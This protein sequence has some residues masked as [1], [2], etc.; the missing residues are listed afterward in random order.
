MSSSGGGVSSSNNN[1]INDATSSLGLKMSGLNLMSN[2]SNSS[3]GPPGLSGSTVSTSSIDDRA[4]PHDSSIDHS[5]SAAGSF[6]GSTPSSPINH[7]EIIGGG[8][9]SRPPGLLGGVGHGS[10]S[11]ASPILGSGGNT[12]PGLHSKNSSTT[13][14][15]LTL[16]PNSSVDG[17]SDLYSRQASPFQVGSDSG[18]PAMPFLRNDG[19]RGDV[20]GDYGGGITSTFGG[21]GSFDLVDND[22]NYNSSASNDNDGLLGLDALRDRAYSSPGPMARSFESAP[23]LRGG[24]PPSG[25]GGGSG[26]GGGGSVV[27]ADAGAPGQRRRGVS[28]NNSGRS[29]G[30]ARP[31]LSGSVH[32]SSTNS[33]PS[34]ELHLGGLS[35][36]AGDMSLGG[37]VVPF[38]SGGRSSDPSPTRQTQAETSSIASL[39]SASE[40][41]SF[42]AIGRPE[43]S[44]NARE[45]EPSNRRRSIAG[46]ETSNLN[47]RA[48]YSQYGN[49]EQGY[50][51]SR[52]RSIGTES[53][54]EFYQQQQQQH[55]PQQH[56]GGGG[57]GYAEHGQDHAMSQKLG[58]LPSMSSQIH[59]KQRMPPHHSG[60]MQPPFNPMMLPQPKHQRSYSQPGPRMAT[61]PDQ[62][63]Q[64]GGSVGR[65][66]PS[67]YQNNGMDNNNSGHYSR[68][69]PPRYIGAP[70]HQGHHV[71][72]HSGDSFRSNQSRRSTSMSHG[73]L[74]VNSYGESGVMQKRNSQ[75][76]LGSG[77]YG[78]Q[79]QVLPN[80]HP[81]MQRGMVSLQPLDLSLVSFLFLCARDSLFLICKLIPAL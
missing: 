29:A 71:R 53:G 22:S 25:G 40:F 55:L 7:H 36:S 60:H 4:H 78:Q 31:P 62:L 69:E 75:P 66:P 72:Q 5:S 54:R 61:P 37:L 76:N 23:S 11:V 63:G 9:L 14:P 58:V 19:Q 70:S 44:G 79:Q 51:A 50:E 21:G 18:G 33:P 65:Y 57:Y 39:A 74:S 41:S 49:E 2:F 30:S 8:A 3:S 24:L 52:R 35:N 48:D 47:T 45:W 1:N 28:R 17:N 26:A 10:S 73:S 6:K 46:T 13:S 27:G 32:N 12:N 81:S 34:R 64:E 15:M 68:N 56:R 43:F 59:Q 20:H 80:M 77:Y 67:G 16:T 38:P 42:G